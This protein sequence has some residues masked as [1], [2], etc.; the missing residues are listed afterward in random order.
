[1][2]AGLQL[3]FNYNSWPPSH[4]LIEMIGCKLS[5]YIPN[6]DHTKNI[7]SNSSR[8]V[9]CISIAA[10]TFIEPLPSNGCLFQP[11][12][13][14]ILDV[15]K[16]NVPGVECRIQVKECITFVTLTSKVE[17]SN[18]THTNIFM[19]HAMRL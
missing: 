17:F 5:L 15:L 4:E 8:I 16:N 6:K 12:C 9:A 2:A 3:T 18:F 19:M 1:M 14:N 13:H 10:Y 11:S 7:V